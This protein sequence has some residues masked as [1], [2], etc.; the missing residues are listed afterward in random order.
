M[1]AFHTGVLPGGGVSGVPR[2]DRKKKEALGMGSLALL[3]LFGLFN[4]SSD[5]TDCP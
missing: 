3:I 1:I 4:D 2:P 5:C